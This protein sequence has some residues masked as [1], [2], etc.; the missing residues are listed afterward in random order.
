MLGRWLMATMVAGLLVPAP[1]IAGGWASVGLSSTPDGTAAGK[2][3]VVDLEVLQHGRTPLAG[4]KPTVTIRKPATGATRTFRARPQSK[5]GI[6]RASVVFPDA[7]RWEY[8]VDDGFSQTNKL[9]EV[10]IAAAG[11]SAGAGDLSATSDGG[12]PWA[13]YGGLLLACFAA[14]GLVVAARRRG[15]RGLGTPT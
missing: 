9:G 13:I 12:A 10:S 5:A 2:P 7:G 6:Y 1:A 15:G 4:V 3:W 14:V 8:I 11:D